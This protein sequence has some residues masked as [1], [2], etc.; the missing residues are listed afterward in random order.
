MTDY[1]WVG[2]WTWT[3]AKQLR[4]KCPYLEAILTVL[5]LRAYKYNQTKVTQVIKGSLLPTYTASVFDR[6]KS[7][8]VLPNDTD[9]YSDDRMRATTI[10]RQNALLSSSVCLKRTT[11]PRQES[12]TRQ[13]CQQSSAGIFWSRC[14][15]S[16]VGFFA[17]PRNMFVFCI[18]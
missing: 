14:I 5:V 3:Q 8:Q 12:W 13:L 18:T 6:C 15:S 16:Q 10:M 11:L 17:F 4:G 2:T 7:L 9:I 1:I